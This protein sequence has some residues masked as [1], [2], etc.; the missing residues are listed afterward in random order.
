MM[1]QTELK[2]LH[3]LYDQIKSTLLTSDPFYKHMLL[4]AWS[5]FKKAP[6]EHISSAVSKQRETD[7]R[8]LYKFFVKNSFLRYEAKARSDML[9]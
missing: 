9:K 8:G 6:N 1:P 4:L 2:D 3:E 7:P 5:E